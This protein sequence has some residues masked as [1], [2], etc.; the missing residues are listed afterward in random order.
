MVRTGFD[1]NLI[2]AIEHGFSYGGI[3]A[4]SMYAVGNLSNGMHII[5]NAIIPHWDGEV[6]V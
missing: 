4:C 3:S 5:G 2:A 6:I 1:K